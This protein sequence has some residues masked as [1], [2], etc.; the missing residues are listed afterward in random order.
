MTAGEEEMALVQG[1]TGLSMKWLTGRSVQGTCG[2]WEKG[3]DRRE[4]AGHEEHEDGCSWS[5][6][7][8]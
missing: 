4:E 6:R 1:P 2:D 7:G 8:G 3:M 5:H